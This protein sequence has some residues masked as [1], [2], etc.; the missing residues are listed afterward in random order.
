[1]AANAF[2]LRRV[3]SLYKRDGPKSSNVTLPEWLTGSPAIYSCQRLCFAREC[4]NRSG[5]DFC[6]TYFIVP[7]IVAVPL[8]LGTVTNFFTHTSPEFRELM[9]VQRRL[10][11]HGYHLDP[12]NHIINPLLNLNHIP[13]HNAFIALQTSFGIFHRALKL[14]ERLPNALLFFFQAFKRAL[15]RCCIGV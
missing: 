6:T 1:M 14:R 4:S 12:T 8:R 3:R 15:E 9:G 5:D 2:V 10:L 13:P 7:F 11:M